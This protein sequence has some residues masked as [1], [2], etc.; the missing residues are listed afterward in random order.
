MM[1]AT[2]DA[3]TG[4]A[5][6]AAVCEMLEPKPE[7]PVRSLIP[8]SVGDLYAAPSESLDA[9]LL[10][11]RELR[12]KRWPGALLMLSETQVGWHSQMEVDEGVHFGEVAD[13]PA[14]AVCLMLLKAAEATNG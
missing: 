12:D 14:R 1:D 13:T 10:A 7:M 2:P 6:D 8:V 3:L 4:R 11:Y 5:L 9:A